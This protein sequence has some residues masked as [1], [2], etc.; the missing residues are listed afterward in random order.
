VG[1][2]LYRY[3]IIIFVLTLALF[4]Q[5]L[6]ASKKYN[7][8]NLGVSQGL[9]Q[10]TVN[11]I[12]QD[13]SGFMWFATENGVNIYDGYH[14]RSLKA[15][16]QLDINNY[17]VYDLRQDENGIVWFTLFG[18]GL[19]T[20]NQKT[21]EY[22]F[23][24]E[25]DP[26]NK[27]YLV[28]A[29]LNHKSGISDWV[30]TSK[31]IGLYHHKT[32]SFEQIVNLKEHLTGYNSIHKVYE[33]KGLLFIATRVGVFVYDLATK[34]LEKFTLNKQTVI[35]NQTFSEHEASKIYDF[36]FSGNRIFIG[37][38]DGVFEGDFRQFQANIA[39][40]KVKMAVPSVG[41]WQLYLDNDTLIM[42]A[43]DGLYQ[44]NLISGFHHLLFRYSDTFNYVGD[45]AVVSFLKDKNGLYWMGSPATGVF[46]WNPKSQLID[47]YQY[48][49][50]D[51]NSLSNGSVFSIEEDFHS[52]GLLWVGTNNGLNLVDT[53]SH[54][55]QRFGV[56]DQSKTEF[57]E[58]NILEVEQGENV[59]W[60]STH[61]G[62]RL[63]DK[64]KREMIPIELPD[65]IL[66]WLSQENVIMFLEDDL[67]WFSGEKGSA[68]INL[69]QQTIEYLGMIDEQVGI[70]NIWNIL[71]SP[72]GQKG[73]VL[74]ITNDNV[75][76]YQKQ[77]KTVKKL[78]QF[79]ERSE[80]E[81]FTI[82]SL[83]IDKNG[84]LWLAYSGIGLVGLDSKTLEQIYFYN[85]KNSVID[86]NVYGLNE[87]KEGNLWF[88]THH[89][90]YRLDINSHHIRKF[91]IEDGLV[92]NEYNAGASAKLKN[93]KLAYGSMQGVT[94][95]NPLVL[96]QATA[97]KSVNLHF[98]NVEVLSRKLEL[99]MFLP[100]NYKVNL[101][102]D[103]VGIRVDFSTFSFNDT[104][105]INFQYELKGPT[106]IKSPLM[107]HNF[108][109]F[110]SLNSGD[111]VLTVQAKSPYTGELSDPISLRFQ[112]SYAPWR[113]PLALFIYSFIAIATIVVWLRSRYIR[114]QELLA[115][116][117]EVK[118]REN[119][120]QLALTGSNSEVWDWFAEENRIYA[121]RI[122]HELEYDSQ[123]NA[124]LMDRHLDLIHPEDRDLFMS[125][126]QVFLMHSNKDDSFECS[127][128]LKH[129]DG[130][131]LWY[132]DLGKVVATNFDGLPSRVTGSYTNITQNK[133]DEERAQHYGEAFRQTKDWVLIVDDKLTKITANQSLRNAF[134]WDKEEFEFDFSIL[135]LRN[136]RLRHYARLLPTIK[137]IGHWTGEELVKTP[138]GDEYHVIL[139]ISCSSNGYIFVLTDISAQKSAEQELR[140]LANYDHLT[141]LPNR[142]LLLERIKHGIEQA[143]RQHTA[144]A[145]FFIDLDRFK[146][147][148]DSL[149]HDYGDMLLKEITSRLT[150]TLRQDDTVARIG[151][152]EFVVLLEDFK[153]NNHLS[154]I[155]QK[156]ID[157]VEKPVHLHN[158]TVSVGASIGI[159]LYPDDSTDQDELL[160][161]ADVA[162]YHAKQQGRNNF[163]FFTE[164][165]NKE[166]KLR[167]NQESNLKLAVQNDEFF[168][169]YQ[170]LI[171]AHTGK[172]VGAEMLMR[173][174]SNEGLIAPSNFIP[175]AEELGLIV[176]MTDMALEKGLSDLKIWRVTREDFYLS[177]N[178][179][180]PHFSDGNFVSFIKDKLDKFNLPAKALKLEVTESAFIKEPDK[181]IKTMNE[182]ANLGCMLAL[183][184]FGT[185]FSSLSYLKKLPLDII[186]I[187]RSFING[188]GVES[189]D[190][191]IVDA[192]LVLAQSLD[193]ACIAEGVETQEQLQYLVDRKCHFIQGF[194]YFPP[195]SSTD[196]TNKL[197]ENKVE[198]VVTSE[199]S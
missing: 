34:K 159:S 173:W 72:T 68:V 17:A 53:I 178:V 100:N 92:A 192:T 136:E 118:F 130:H 80:F 6:H 124:L 177:I 9:S 62:I 31:T 66:K 18:K 164:H 141:G 198:L 156:I 182:L 162:M 24:M 167:L 63:F 189:A 126:W 41:I 74:F 120:L 28:V 151:G 117:E 38:N 88:S 142:S 102:Y 35:E 121:K 90:I 7:L 89:G 58:G 57:T 165:M 21:D 33:Y 137:D 146:H 71:S 65:E 10:G 127:Y 36:A 144:L 191:A 91:D 56:T 125:K 128:R 163:Q 157:V 67:L 149:G 73:D 196:M 39:N 61:Q 172:A 16:E 32:Q 29:S 78:L 70:N 1:K 46:Y 104:D 153:S 60:L 138:S 26:E 101:S 30:I 176:Q 12:M 161:N 135:G 14:F 113:S 37:T 190:E 87:D 13:S 2:S 169:L 52:P 95:F 5:S 147:V 79:E 166:A 96:H 194:L 55:I 107:A 85:D 76:V 131:W 108:V 103:D 112:V 114:Q 197:N 86:A 111:Y 98:A 4:S 195:L 106:Y 54:S 155:A 47:N 3:L 134:H 25:H 129:K 145:A 139:N 181:A 140:L 82:D 116:H 22:K 99:P 188:I 43:N 45:N 185:G 40:A 42:G 174:Q 175:L 48:S 77:T 105:L 170:P 44:Y 187:D 148:N 97:G 75:W 133:V 69:Q 49:S 115:A 193:M 84:I 143:N 51:N 179:S 11:T 132:K 183:D 152:D 94:V 20:Y 8:K 93:G 109:I 199:K 64:E 158:N 184:D 186:K 150:G 119:R 19:Y 59:L 81:F 23:V 180:A 160:R 122:S 110:P 123:D 83:V 27:D 50:T 154:H 171:D 168:N 15:P